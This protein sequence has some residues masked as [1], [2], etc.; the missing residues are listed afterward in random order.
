[1]AENENRRKG[2][3]MSLITQ[4]VI[5]IVVF[6]VITAVSVNVNSIHKHKVEA[7]KMTQSYLEDLATE[8]G[9]KI[10]MMLNMFNS[11]SETTL[12]VVNDDG[13]FPEISEDSSFPDMTENKGN[14]SQGRPESGRPRGMNMEQ[15]LSEI[16]F[17]GYEI[18]VLLADADG[19]YTYDSDDSKTD[20]A[21]KIPEIL[22]LLDRAADGTLAAKTSDTTEVKIDGKVYDFA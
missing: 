7:V 18:E 9:S 17:Q 5:L 20:T 2:L 12:T 4:L 3:N 16:S 19:T 13:A 6:V 21:V 15:M 10:T 14:F 22:E 8:S 1:M 11:S